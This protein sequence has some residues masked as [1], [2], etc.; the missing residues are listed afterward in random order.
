ME[1]CHAEG[2]LRSRLRAS[3]SRGVGERGCWGMIAWERKL[4]IFS[5]YAGMCTI[6]HHLTG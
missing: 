1:G 5:A 4:V 3:V 6:R 2:L